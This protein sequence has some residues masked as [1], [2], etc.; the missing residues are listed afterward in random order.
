[1]S[2]RLSKEFYVLRDRFGEV[3]ELDAELDRLDLE[4]DLPRRLRW[5]ET[6]AKLEALGFDREKLRQPPPIHARIIVAAQAREQ[7]A[8]RFDAEEAGWNRA[9][10]HRRDVVLDRPD[11]SAVIYHWVRAW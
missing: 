9:G 6:A 7:R 1:M 2:R 10:L 5:K 8:R 11:G 3:A 4:I